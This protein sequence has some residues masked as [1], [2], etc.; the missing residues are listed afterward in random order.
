MFKLTDI[1][2]VLFFTT[3]I[4]FMVTVTAWRVG[5][6]KTGRCFALAM[7]SI[8]LWTLAVGLGYASVPLNLKILFA[9]V[10]A[11]SYNF[12]L[13][14]FLLSAMY[15]TGLDE[16]SDHKWVR[17]FIFFLPASSILLI[18]TNEFHHW[19]WTGFRPVRDNIIVF[20]HGPGFIWVAVA[21]YL[22][23]LFII[24]V[25]LR[26]STQ[27]SEISR[28]QGRILFGATLFPLAANLFYLHGVKGTEGVDW[29][30]ST[31]SVT[32][33][34]FLWALYGEHFTDIIPIAYDT[35]VNSIRDGMIVLDL[36]NRIVDI[37]Q[38]A[39]QRLGGEV[40]AFLGKNM[41]NVVPNT[42]SILELPMEQEQKIELE[43]GEANNRYFDILISPLYD[44]RYKFVAGRLIISRDIT[45]QKIAKKAL[46]QQLFEIQILHQAL[47]DTQA[48]LVEQ[49]RELAKV[50]ERQRIARNLHDSLSQSIHSLGLFSDTL[51]AAI[52]RNDLKRARQILERVQE[53][54]RQAHKE[55]RLLL[56]EL[57][58]PTIERVIDLVQ[59]LEE[60]LEKV[61]RHTGV[62]AQIILEGSLEHCPQE[63]YENLFW[64]TIEAL[65]NALKHAFAQNVQVCICCSLQSMELD[66]ND[67]G[68]GFNVEEVYAGG[69]GL[70]NLRARAQLLG[71]TLTIESQ[72]EKGTTVH[73]RVAIPLTA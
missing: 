48:Q 53:S 66:V 69:M 36:Q 61:E 33:L 58:N 40:S 38:I 11:A 7:T 45:S 22:I 72:P 37:N 18:V 8:T 24:A 12:S 4:N 27:G 2:V 52:D 57:Q 43:S 17:A 73:L 28:R 60:R 41:A 6:T 20:E 42:R 21:G 9:K 63:W 30:S 65:N 25:L 54:A 56:Y 26:A 68:I 5:K 35:L 70:D 64:I 51:A 3:A 62:K 31:F 46:E 59:S 49:Q 29:S 32:G 1:A 23:L 13:P 55:T 15:M 44:R 47:Q 50:E 16:W 71:G 67:N 39:A 14:L 19:V 34:L 10:D